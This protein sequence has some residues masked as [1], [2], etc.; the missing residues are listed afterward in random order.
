MKETAQPKPPEALLAASLYDAGDVAGAAAQLE[1]LV[2]RCYPQ[3][4]ADCPDEA[5]VRSDLGAQYHQSDALVEA[6]VQLRRAVELEPT[7]GV[8]LNN[9]A[10][11][12]N[13][14]GKKEEADLVYEQALEAVKARIQPSLVSVSSY[15]W[16]RLPNHRVPF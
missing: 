10:V 4:G 14:L 2:R 13:S 7:N 12:L 15:V 3:G 8:A 11:T 1:S 9:L 16:D 5:K 6:E